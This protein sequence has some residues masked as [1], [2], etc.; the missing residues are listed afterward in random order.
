VAP[1]RAS[2][3]ANATHRRPRGQ[4]R[5][6][7][8]RAV[9]PGASATDIPH[10]TIERDRAARSG[11]PCAGRCARPPSPGCVAGTRAL[12][13]TANAI[14]LR[15]APAWTGGAGGCR[16]VPRSLKRPPTA[17]APGPVAAI[18]MCCA[19]AGL[20]ATSGSHWAVAGRYAPR[21]TASSCPKGTRSAAA[22]IPHGSP[23]PGTQTP[24]ARQLGRQ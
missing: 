7:P 20:W 24:T 12:A 16:A 17:D 19:A 4:P 18:R 1:H 21:C 6:L 3:R 14:M 10:S 11:R 5:P 13:A 8:A 15:H 9:P 22:G 23:D 2:A